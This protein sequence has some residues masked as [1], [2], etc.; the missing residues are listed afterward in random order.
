MAQ[1]LRLLAPSVKHQPFSSVGRIRASGAA[2]ENQLGCIIPFKEK[3]TAFQSRD[4]CHWARI[5]FKPDF[6]VTLALPGGKQEGKNEKT[7]NAY[8]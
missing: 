7:Y 1:Q 5:D 2:N 8:A 6:P 3:H 4:L